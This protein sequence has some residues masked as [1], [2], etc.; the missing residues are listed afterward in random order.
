MATQEEECFIC[1]SCG[2][3]FQQKK[4]LSQHI[5]KLHSNEKDIGEGN[6]VKESCCNNT[7]DTLQQR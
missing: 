4:Y 7:S 1:N 6:N 2:R 3:L 5:S